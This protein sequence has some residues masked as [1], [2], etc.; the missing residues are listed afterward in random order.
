MKRIRIID[1]LTKPEIGKE[2]NVKGWV[3]AFRSNRFIQLTD[4][5]T[6][7]T[8]QAV[9]DFEQFDEALL[10]KITTAAAL[11]LTGTLIESQ[12]AG[13]AVE[14]QVSSIEILGEANPDDVQKTV[15]QPK[16]HSL[17]FL[18]EQ[19]HLRFRTNTFGAVFRIRHAVALSL[20]RSINFSTTKVSFT[21][22]LPLLLVRMRK[23]QERCS[24]FPP[25]MLK[26][27]R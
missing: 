19:A 20:I 8:L 4:G 25:W 22:I 13:Q 26:T 27:L 21:Y 9:V 16:K 10:K 6:I 15:M 7:N 23:V 2:I 18:R 1:I 17:E 12:G 24:A 14:L 11:S 3:R 5:S